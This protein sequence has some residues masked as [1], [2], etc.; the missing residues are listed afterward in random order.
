MP[1]CE[2]PLKI[3]LVKSGKHTNGYNTMKATF[4][5][6]AVLFS[7]SV[8]AQK[9]SL[10]GKIYGARPDT[11]G[12]IAA[13]KAESSMDKKTRISAALKGRVIKVTREKGGWF[14]LDG[15][16][17]KIIEAHFKD[18]N[19]SIP[20]TLKGKTVIIDCV[21]QKQFIADDQQH[22][23]GDTVKGKKQSQVKTNPKR[24]LTLEVNGLMVE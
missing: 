15:G 24:R 4:L 3:P 1:A 18:Y 5:L 19:I 21:V 11:T 14:E 23:A 2:K 17:G 10:H 9:T 22:F 12:V 20:T 13:S 8:Y 16:R 6:L 7:F